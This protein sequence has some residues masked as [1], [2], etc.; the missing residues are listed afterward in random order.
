[1]PCNPGERIGDPND[2]QIYY[3]C[4]AAGNGYTQ[5]GCDEHYSFDYRPKKQKCRDT[6]RVSTSKIKC[7]PSCEELAR[8]RGEAPPAVNNV[9][10]ATER[11]FLNEEKVTT[12][13]ATTT[14][15]ASTTPTATQKSQ[16]SSRSRQEIEVFASGDATTQDKMA[17]TTQPVN[18]QTTAAAAPKS[19]VGAKST[20]PPVVV[21]P[22]ESPKP[23]Y[24]IVT[25]APSDGGV[26]GGGGRWCHRVVKIEYSF[27]A[28]R[29]PTSFAT[30]FCLPGQCYTVIDNWL[31]VLVTWQVAAPQVDPVPTLSS[32]VLLLAVLSSSSLSLLSSS[33][34]LGNESLE[35]STY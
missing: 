25:D 29:A 30:L 20:A 28:S 31:Q 26:T 1:M 7:S 24:I 35:K 33:F 8:L 9:E 6:R 13:S 14:T 15:I 16:E 5:L 22:S 4:N 23:P 11:K 21:V 2:C 3:E 34:C 17:P 19:T 10:S 12:Q 18:E 32:L 27:L